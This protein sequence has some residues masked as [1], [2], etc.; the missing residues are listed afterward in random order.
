MRI[1]L[2]IPCLV[3][4]IQPSSASLSTAWAA[5]SGS[6]WRFFHLKM[7]NKLEEGNKGFLQQDREGPSIE[8]KGSIRKK[9]E[10]PLSFINKNK[11]SII[12]KH[13]D[14]EEYRNARIEALL[15]RIIKYRKGKIVNMKRFVPLNALL[16]NKLAS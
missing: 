11:Y 6:L 10:I 9:N 13:E 3:M 15:E 7:K 16:S 8:I 5:Y 4:I 12:Q 14:T 1:Y 2:L